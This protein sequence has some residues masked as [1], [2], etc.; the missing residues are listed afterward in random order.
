MGTGQDDSHWEAVTNL[1]NKFDLTQSQST[2]HPKKA[3]VIH[4]VKFGSS[5]FLFGQLR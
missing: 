5:T 3:N 2:H 1:A 4:Q